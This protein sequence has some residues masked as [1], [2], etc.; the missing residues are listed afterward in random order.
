MPVP[1]GER[2]Y[3]GKLSLRL[4]PEQ[5][6]RVAVQAAQQNVSINRYIAARVYPHEE[7]TSIFSD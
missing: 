1:L 6:R 5:H 4:T 7:G 2:R 3:S